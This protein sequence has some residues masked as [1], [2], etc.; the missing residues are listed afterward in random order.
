VFHLP[1][2]M[3][4]SLLLLLGLSGSLMADETASQLF[5]EKSKQVFQIKVIDKGSG[6]KSSIGSGFQVSADGVL[7]TNYH[8]VSDYV[9][10]PEKYSIE[11]LDDE[12]K[13]YP[14][15]LLNFDIVHDLA[16]LK[17]EHPRESH[18]AFN[19]NALPNGERIYSLGNPHDLG[20]L[21]IE[22]NY[23]GLV[24]GSRYR[25]YLFSG[26]LNGGMSGGPTLNR[27]G[28]VIGINV[29]K[30]GEQLSF[31]VPVEHL[32]TLLIQSKDALAV[33]HYNEHA[34]T[35]LMADQDAYFSRLLK[36]NWNSKTF[37]QYS[38]PDSFH[39]SLKCWGHSEDK[40]DNRYGETHRHCR[41]EDRIYLSNTLYTGGFAFDYEHITKGELNNLQFYN[42]LEQNLNMPDFNN[43]NED[44]TSNFKCSSRMIE[45]PG[46]VEATP[47]EWKVSTCI[48]EYHDYRG[49]YDAGLL[50]MHAGNHRKGN[51]ALK[52][53]LGISG[54]DRANLVRV[55]Q[56]FLESVQWAK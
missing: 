7:A 55:H 35:A 4:N 46:K 41:T 3:I 25:K 18:F 47:T 32:Q 24:E 36:L 42:L 27:R 12:A 49:F 8:V 30:G 43:G 45:L 16:L 48:R 21:I 13:T 15:A 37:Q 19:L 33:T 28:E 23:N 52:I 26:S 9:L 39:N 40:K 5:A 22:G 11:V 34:R 50:A 44:D 17:I 53:Y 1:L 29:S 20:M 14:A 2:L 6:N 56:K 38:L 31:L 51:S 54:I 10:E